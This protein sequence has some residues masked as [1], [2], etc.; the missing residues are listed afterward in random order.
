[1]TDFNPLTLLPPKG[2]KIAYAA[3]GTVGLVVTAAGAYCI[4]TDITAPTVLVGA[5]GVVAA[6]VAP[7]SVLAASN[8]DA[9][10]GTKTV[11][12]TSPDVT[13]R[14]HY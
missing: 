9:E 5:A 12:G 14:G 2:R 1:V 11:G 10:Q 4:A 8:V 6:L 3:Y 13:G 7:F